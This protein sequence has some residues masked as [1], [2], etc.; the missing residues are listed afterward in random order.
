MRKFFVPF[1]FLSICWTL[2]VG[3]VVLVGQQNYRMNANDPQIQDVEDVVTALNAGQQLSLQPDGTDV[4]K[5]LSTFIVLYDSTGKAVSSN[6]VLDGKIPQIPAG[7]FAYINKHNGAED[8]F[9][10]QPKD[11]ERFAVVV[12]KTSQSNQFVAVG[13]SLREVE[14]R[15]GDLS[16]YAVIVW[17]FLILVTLLGCYWV[18]EGCP[19]PRCI[20]KRKGAHHH[21]EHDHQAE[22]TEVVNE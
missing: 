22:P 3:F 20:G 12:S 9:T 18:V 13:R 10:W 16:R 6:V 17:T 8:R 5:S 19:C 7:V 21:H 11:G 1:I 14:V 4:S 15:E 2:L